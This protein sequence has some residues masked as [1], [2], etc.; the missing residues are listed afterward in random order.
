MATSPQY[1]TVALQ[2][3]DEYGVSE[4]GFGITMKSAAIASGAAR[5]TIYR[6]WEVVAELNDDMARFVVGDVEGWQRRVLADD[7]AHDLGAAIAASMST[8]G[9][10]PGAGRRM[11]L[12]GW[13]ADRPGRVFARQWEAAWLDAYATHLANHLGSTG[14]RVVPVLGPGADPEALDHAGDAQAAARRVV[15]VG[16]AAMVEGAHIFAL[17]KHGPDPVNWDAGFGPAIGRAVTRF[18]DL[19]VEPDPSATSAGWEPVVPD[20]LPDSGLGGAKA[21]H[22]GRILE[23]IRLHPFGSE[24]SPAPPRLV[25]MA[26]L[27][28]RAELSERWLYELWPTVASCNADLLVA[29]L[30]RDQDITAEQAFAML[31]AGFSASGP[32]DYARMWAEGLQSC[33]EALLAPGRI[34]VLGA[35][36]GL[37]DPDV[38]ERMTGFNKAP[39]QVGRGVLLSLLGMI[40]EQ[41]QPE[42]CADEFNDTMFSTV[43]GL[44][45]LA[46]LHPE[47]LTERAWFE[48][49][50]LPLCGLI[51]LLVK[52]SMSAPEAL[53]ASE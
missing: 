17:Y 4:P 32:P 44:L 42:V 24:G 6:H 36:Q 45:R 38:R 53:P 18:V 7:P 8:A 22:L 47:L 10:E 13:P 33:I 21:D 46:L 48:G 28:R 29:V 9:I 26:R 12:V 20:P 16:I 35:A 41:L 25:D 3:L 43:L 19:L 39:G 5:S 30:D 1:V 23:H 40:G 49:R 27:A 51:C 52:N 31:S 50:D 34:T 2:L 14:H 11:L 15:A 37:M